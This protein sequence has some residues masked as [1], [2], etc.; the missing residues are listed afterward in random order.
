[1]KAVIITSE[2]T[3][4]LKAKNGGVATRTSAA[5]R[6]IDGP[7]SRRPMAAT[8]ATVPSAD[9]IDGNAAVNSVTRPAGSDTSAMLQN[10]VAVC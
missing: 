3:A 1:M 5:S 2:S 9:T 8:A 6:P 4:W 10:T 7:H